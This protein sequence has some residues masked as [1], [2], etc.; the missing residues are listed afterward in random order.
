MAPKSE[1]EE[2]D[3]FEASLR[4]LSLG[5]LVDKLVTYKIEETLASEDETVTEKSKRT[6]RMTAIKD[7]ISRR[8]VGREDN[9]LSASKGVSSLGSLF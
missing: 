7:E 8:E 6:L 5:N 9:D 3:E 4:L 1:L 2:L